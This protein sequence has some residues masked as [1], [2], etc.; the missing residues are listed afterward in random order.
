MNPQSRKSPHMGEE[1]P[2]AIT[3]VKCPTG[4]ARDAALREGGSVQTY[5]QI[6]ML[7]LR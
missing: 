6:D 2:M 5:S 3:V 1:R 7:G 4:R